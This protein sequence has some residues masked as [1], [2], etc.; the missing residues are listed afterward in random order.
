MLGTSRCLASAD[1]AVSAASKKPELLFF[2]KKFWF[3]VGRISR[4]EADLP[5]VRSAFHAHYRKIVCVETDAGHLE[6][7][8]ISPALRQ[9]F[10]AHRLT[11]SPVRFTDIQGTVEARPPH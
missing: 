3:L 11:C 7:P 9:G 4:E 6:V 8:S 1:T 10:H 2:E 5:N